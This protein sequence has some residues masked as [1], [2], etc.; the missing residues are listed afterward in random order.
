M[1]KLG[2]KD[3]LGSPKTGCVTLEVVRTLVTCGRETS[4]SSDTIETNIWLITRAVSSMD[5]EVPTPPN[6]LSVSC[7]SIFG[8]Y[9][10]EGKY[11]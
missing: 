7:S 2:R 4:T 11:F 5:I 9:L 10:L 8:C 3:G 1:I 6:V